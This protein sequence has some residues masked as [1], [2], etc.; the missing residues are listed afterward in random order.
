ME[1]TDK[2]EPVEK[3]PEVQ[4]LLIEQTPLEE[5]W[6]NVLVSLE[7]KFG[8]PTANSWFRPLQVM[9]FDAGTLTYRAPTKFISDWVQSRYLACLRTAWKAVGYDV[10]AIAFVSKREKAAA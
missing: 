3:A 7:K 5:A 8:T 9:S 4:L 10:E 6:D 1:R 2:R